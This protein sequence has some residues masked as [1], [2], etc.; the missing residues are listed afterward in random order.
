MGE[1]VKEWNRKKFLVVIM[2]EWYGFDYVC[3]WILFW[4]NMFFVY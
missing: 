3:L 1:L 2:V 4:K